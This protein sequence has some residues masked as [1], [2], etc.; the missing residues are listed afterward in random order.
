MCTDNQLLKILSPKYLNYTEDMN[1]SQTK[2]TKARELI[3]STIKVTGGG[4]YKYAELIEQK[5]G[6]KISKKD[7]MECMIRGCNFLLK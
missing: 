2:Q 1:N 3:G 7:E 5:L 6:L 4:A